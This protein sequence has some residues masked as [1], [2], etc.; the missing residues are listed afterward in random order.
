MQEG[1]DDAV[2]STACPTLEQDAE[3]SS[4]SLHPAEGIAYSLAEVWYSCLQADGSAA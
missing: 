2:H 4:S 3:C 1:G